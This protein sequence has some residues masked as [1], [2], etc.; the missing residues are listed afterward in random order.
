MR[1]NS[2]FQAFSKFRTENFLWSLLP[3]NM[4]PHFEHFH[5][6]LISAANLEIS[7]NVQEN[8]NLSVRGQ[9]SSQPALKIHRNFRKLSEHN[10]SCIQDFP[11]KSLKFTTLFS[12]NAYSSAYK[13]ACKSKHCPASW[14]NSRSSTKSNK[15]LRKQ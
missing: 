7:R 12:E 5:K 2:I 3:L 9:E 14:L 10:F 13:S 11:I 15:S 8:Y 4:N 1:E 6:I